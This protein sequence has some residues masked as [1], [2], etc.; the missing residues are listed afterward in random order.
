MIRDEFR[1]KR[2]KIVEAPGPEEMEDAM[3][4][5]IARLVQERYAVSNVIA[6]PDSRGTGKAWWG[7]IVYY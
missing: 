4:I 2:I 6:K 1:P 5:A 3:D 7:V